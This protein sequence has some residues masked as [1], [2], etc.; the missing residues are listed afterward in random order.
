MAGTSDDEG[1]DAGALFQ[2]PEGF[3]QPE[4]EPTF[5][6]Y[7]MQDGEELNL[8]LVGHNPLWVGTLFCFFP[9]FGGREI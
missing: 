5:V 7:Q 9:I 1:G 8:R 2:E 3:Y 4:K 6:K